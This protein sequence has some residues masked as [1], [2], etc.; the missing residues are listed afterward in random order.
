MA[1]GSEVSGWKLSNDQSD[2][3]D[4]K[5]DA[6]PLGFRNILLQDTASQNDG[7]RRVHGRENRSDVE[8]GELDRQ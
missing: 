3:Q 8:A 7:R 4:A 1:V 6:K 5:H 2:R